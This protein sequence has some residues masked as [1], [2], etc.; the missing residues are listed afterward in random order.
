MQVTKAFWSQVK[1]ECRVT[2]ALCWGALGKEVGALTLESG[3]GMCRQHDPFFQASR[4]SLVYQ[5]PSVHCPCAPI[6]NLL[7]KFA[8]WALFWPKFQLSRCIFSK[9]SFP[10]PII[11]Q[12]KSWKSVGHTHQKKKKKKSCV[13][14]PRVEV[15]DL[16][17]LSVDYSLA[18]PKMVCYVQPDRQQ[19]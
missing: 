5:L 3:T 6:F 1:P 14:L 11:C 8:F 7:K 16:H 12:E 19:L 18:V 9:F 10:R 4:S 15:W 17:S 2:R 13:P